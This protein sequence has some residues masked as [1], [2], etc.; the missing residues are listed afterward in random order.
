MI[1]I[2][3][4]SSYRHVSRS[5]DICAYCCGHKYGCRFEAAG[6]SHGFF[7]LSLSFQTCFVQLSLRVRSHGLLVYRLCLLPDTPIIYTMHVT[8]WSHLLLVISKLTILLSFVFLFIGFQFINFF[9]FCY[10]LLANEG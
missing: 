10:T 1:L 3:R 7:L 4:F 2:A 9:S 5:A 6:S 8:Y